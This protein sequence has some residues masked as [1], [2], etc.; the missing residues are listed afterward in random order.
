M[1]NPAFI[2]FLFSLFLLSTGFTTGAFGQN[3]PMLEWYQ[4]ADSM[5]QFPPID[6]KLEMVDKKIGKYFVTMVGIKG[7]PE[8][9]LM[10]ITLQKITDVKS[11][12]LTVNFDGIK[13]KMGEVTTWAYVF[14]RNRDGKVDYI[15]LLTAAAAYEG[16]DFPEDFPEGK[17][18][19]NREQQE[20]FIGHAKLVFDH[21][22]DDNFDG[23]LDACVINDLDPVRDMVMRQIVVRSSKFNYS[24]DDVW[25]FRFNI[26]SPR[27]T[28]PHTAKEV[29]YRPITQ[30]KGKIAK[31]S[32]QEKD[33]IL[34]LINGAA[35]A[36]QLI[37]E[38]FYH[39][40]GPGMRSAVLVHLF[41]R[42]SHRS[43]PHPRATGSRQSIQ[44]SV[45]FRISSSIPLSP[46]RRT[47]NF[48]R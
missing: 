30:G 34:E 46:I 16:D 35:K 29:K 20:Y 38:N 33:A 42:K 39:P 43:F 36:F 37:D 32:F 48:R 13:P 12:E 1:S 40:G 4:S 8:V 28:I 45:P 47:S 19:L 15:A 23:K 18:G 22:A 31:S 25:A 3:L 27:E 7:Q 5:T 9:L 10:A 6:Q 44:T 26:N 21:W 24:L 14:D 41:C 17:S 2:K 11:I